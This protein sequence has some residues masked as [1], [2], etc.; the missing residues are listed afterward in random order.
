MYA[1]NAISE[2]N[3]APAFYDPAGGTPALASNNT[4]NALITSSTAN[5]TTVPPTTPAGFMPA[6]GSYAIG[7]G[8]SVPVWSDFNLIPLTSSSTRDMGAVHQ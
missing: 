3:G 5:L 1:P 8:A 6:S 4:S 2:S 7:A